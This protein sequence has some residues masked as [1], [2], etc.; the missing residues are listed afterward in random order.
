MTGFGQ[1]VPVLPVPP[2]EPPAPPL[3][4]EHPPLGPVP[5]SARYDSLT[6]DGLDMET[7]DVAAAATV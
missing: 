6:P 2:L 3:L 7:L 5:P 4:V 1:F